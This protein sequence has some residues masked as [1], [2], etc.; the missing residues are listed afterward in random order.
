MDPKL[1]NL[2]G[3]GKYQLDAENRLTRAGR[4]IPLPP[5]E[6]A[7][8]RLL[9]E[10]P[11]R[12]VS[13]RDFF[14]QLWPG[15]APSDESLTRCIYALRHI[16]HDTRKPH[17]FIE[18]VHGR[19]YRFVATFQR[20]AH[21]GHPA[22][23]VEP[24]SPASPRVCEALQH[25]RWL[26]DER[27]PEHIE[28]AVAILKQALEW[29]PCYAPAH[30]ALSAC[31]VI[32]M[33][34]GQG[35][36]RELAPK[37]LEAAVHALELDPGTAAAKATVA[38][39]CSLVDWAPVEADALFKRAIE[40][41]R[42]SSLSRYLATLHLIGQGRAEE[43]VQ[44][45]RAAVALDP[46][47]LALNSQLAYALYASRR[48]ESALECARRAVELGPSHGPAYGPVALANHELGQFDEALSAARRWVVLSPDAPG[49]RAT[50][51]RALAQKGQ[52]AEA[53]AMLARAWREASDR[54]IVPST[55]AAAA[56]ALRDRAGAF[57][58]LDLAVAQRCCYLAPMLADPSLDGPRKDD[59]FR[60]FVA[61]VRGEQALQSPARRDSRP[62]A[63]SLVG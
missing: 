49:A 44:C 2:L 9:A 24:A 37:I 3:F 28:R 52:R 58:W 16:L 38:Y 30:G 5:K 57:A 17:R 18:T 36:P 60:R 51:A 50:L 33:W 13:K 31:Y 20:A 8:L 27:S 1:P 23:R 56:W 39:V 47:S 10:H 40:S 6:G 43:A 26:L 7:V 12:T 55:Y 45:A 15:V 22:A 63:T 46:F 42:T 34:W 4:P 19:G 21:R 29:E 14:E 53:A 48:Y 54:Y 62:S 25:A 59:R 41:D 35:F 11:A 61:A 32:M